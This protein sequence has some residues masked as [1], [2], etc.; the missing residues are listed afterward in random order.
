MYLAILLNYRYYNWNCRTRVPAGCQHQKIRFARV[1][2][3]PGSIILHSLRRSDNIYKVIV[4]ETFNPTR[5]SLPALYTVRPSHAHRYWTQLH[6]RQSCR[7]SLHL[8]RENERNVLT[9]FG[10]RLTGTVSTG[11]MA[12]ASIISTNFMPRGPQKVLKFQSHRTWGS[13]VIPELAISAVAFQ[14]VVIF[15]IFV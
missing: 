9:E 6:L 4:L 13:S 1:K 5:E 3:S 8:R 15:S 2:K 11:F 10:L 12:C 7:S 14:A